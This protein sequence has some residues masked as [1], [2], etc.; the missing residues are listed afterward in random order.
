MSIPC[1][2]RPSWV[3]VPLTPFCSSLQGSPPRPM[4]EPSVP[5]ALEVSAAAGDPHHDGAG[6]C[7]RVLPPP[8]RS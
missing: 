1:T 8:P 5:W 3:E 4:E 6:S 2:Q 7:T